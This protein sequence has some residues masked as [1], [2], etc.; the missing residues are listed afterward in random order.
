VNSNRA[1]HLPHMRET[2]PCPHCAGDVYLERDVELDLSILRY[3][4]CPGCAEPFV[5]LKRP[6][7]LERDER[8][9]A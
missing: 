6:H 8:D 9:A 1:S 2:T 7:E 4:V 3:L 5:R